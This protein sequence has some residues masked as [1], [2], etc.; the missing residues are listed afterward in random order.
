MHTLKK[1]G[2]FLFVFIAAFAMGI[3]CEKMINS[4]YPHKYNENTNSERE[5]TNSDM[6]YTDGENI[7]SPVIQNDEIIT[8]DTKF[9]IIEHNLD[10]GEEFSSEN[11]VP[12][13]YIGLNRERFLEEMEFY[14]ISPALSDIKKGFRSLQVLSFS[15]KEITLQKNYSDNQIQVHFYIVAKDNKLIVYYEDMETV[16]LTTDISMDSLPTDVQL[17]ILKKKYFETEE[18]LYN[19]LE[20]YSS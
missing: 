2:A 4:F 5:Y 19:F 15:G 11:A 12:I 9:I 1:I 13:K 3:F 16:F 14:E 18:E 20:S 6:D 8:A 10:S 17:E 7:V